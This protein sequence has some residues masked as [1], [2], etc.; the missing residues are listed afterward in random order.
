VIALDISFS[1]NIKTAQNTLPRTLGI[2]L[3]LMKQESVVFNCLE[4]AKENLYIETCKD[5]R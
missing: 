5:A 4:V 1:I 2:F 3:S